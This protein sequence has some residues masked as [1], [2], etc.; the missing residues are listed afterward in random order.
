[1]I[2]AKSTMSMVDW[3]VHSNTPLWCDG[4]DRAFEKMV[5]RCVW[6]MKAMAFGLMRTLN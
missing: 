2:H 4:E 5:A 1:M 3:I 6:H